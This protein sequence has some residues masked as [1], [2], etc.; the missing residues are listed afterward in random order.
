MSTMTWVEP[1][2]LANDTIWLVPVLTVTRLAMVSPGAKLTVELV[3]CA[4]PAGHTDTKLP[5]VDA[6]AVTFM[7]TAV[8]E[9]GTV[10]VPPPATWR[11]RGVPAAN[12]PNQAPVTVR[13]S[14]MRLGA[15]GW[16][17]APARGDTPAVAAEGGPWPWL[18][19]A[20]TVKV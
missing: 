16:N 13:E 15:N 11:V 18:Y 10:P 12:G 8:A 2:A 20:R 19:V 17:P 5:A 1:T 4:W 3:G 6:V 7:T 14:R 9:L